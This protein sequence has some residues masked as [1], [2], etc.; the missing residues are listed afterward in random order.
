MIPQ[1]SRILA[2]VL[3]LTGFIASATA[4]PPPAIHSGPFCGVNSLYTALRIE[5]LNLE[6]P[7]LLQRKYVSSASGGTLPELLQAARDTGANAQLVENLSV[8]DL[9]RLSCPAI[10]HVKTEFDAPDYNH[11]VL[12]VP[13]PDGRL[14]LYD[15]PGPLIRTA[16]H[17]LAPVWDGTALLVSTQ[18]INLKTLRLWALARAALGVGT[19]LAAIGVVVLARSIHQRRVVT[20]RLRL[21]PLAQCSLLVCAAV[22][23]ATVYHVF[24]PEGFFAQRHVVVAI[25]DS[26]KP[27]ARIELSRTRELW[28]Q[29]ALFIDARR[30]ED[31]EQGHIAG[32][33]NIPLDTSRSDRAQ[34]LAKRSN[35]AP[36]VVYC[37]S[38]ACPYATLLARRLSRQGFGNI[39]VFTGGWVEWRDTAG[40][41]AQVS[42][43]VAPMEGGS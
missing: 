17:D 13:A 10:L 16:G 42:T 5:G 4:Q 24:D 41:H 3:A 23:A 27:P 7:R 14:A 11:F 18:P 30:A 19:A 1:Q 25:S 35:T 37:E 2:T 40:T 12:C 15:P 22:S 9:H 33:I 21:G 31:Y 20:S 36:L 34:L 43:V 38:S 39:S 32:A 8:A 26:A 6:F 29:G 28:K